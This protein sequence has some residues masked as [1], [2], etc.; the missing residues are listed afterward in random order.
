MSRV[1]DLDRG[2][3]DE[4]GH[5]PHKRMCELASVSH[6]RSSDWPFLFSADERG[7]TINRP[8]LRKKSG[9]S[10]KGI[11]EALL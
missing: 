2:V 3:G 11:G 6:R 10:F 4:E 1:R 5:S 7:I 9:D 8:P